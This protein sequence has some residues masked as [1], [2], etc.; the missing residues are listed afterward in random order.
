M[1][2]V[3]FLSIWGAV[4]ERGPFTGPTPLSNVLSLQLFLLFAAIPFMVLAALVEERKQSEEALKK[5]EEK[6]SKA[7]RV[8]PVALT[9]TS[10]KDHRYI[11]VNDTFE[12]FTGY[13]REEVI[14]RTPFDMGLWVDPF[15]REEIRKRLLSEGGFRDLEARCRVKDGS[16]RIALGSGE[17]IEIE[18]QPC[19]LAVISDITERKL[20]E[21][22]VANMS[23]AVIAAEEC[24]RSRIAKD[25][26]EDVG[27]RLALLT[28]EIE[29][30]KTEPLHQTVEMLTRIDQLWKHT[31]GILTDVK[32]SA[33]ELHSPR[34]EYLSIEAV[35]RSFCE[36]FGQRK[37][38]KI[39]FRSHDLPS[40]VP[41]DISLCLFRVLQEAL[42]NAVK[43][44]GVRH[45]EVELWGQPGEIH[46][47]VSDSGSGFDPESARSDGGLGLIG[48][49]ERVR[50][51][52][53]TFSIESQPRRGT[54]IHARVP[55]SSRIDSMAS[56][57]DKG[58]TVVST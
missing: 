26:H 44:S 28:I 49:Q 9:V 11:E 31:L 46:L 1:I 29:R 8:S 48:M 21:E 37:G 41:P 14:G 18:G 52:K 53:G 32:T 25:L 36:E 20:A 5:S 38:M 55:L 58:I 15:Q 42:Y 22:A 39:D 7:F 50:L 17:L 30:L 16:I 2:L 27:Q 40:L 6:F 33:H 19:M 4:H 23:R 43:H 57:P 51:L 54:K 13:R 24:E 12:L 45:F 47:T 34:L 3:A 35:M 56:G 10:A